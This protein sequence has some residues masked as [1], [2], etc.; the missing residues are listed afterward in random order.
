MLQGWTLAL[1]GGDNFAQLVQWT[2]LVG[3]ALLVFLG[4]RLLGSGR[5][6]SLF[7]AALFV[8]LPQPIIQAATAQNDLIVSFFVAAT[9]VFG[10]RGLQ[11]RA[12]GDL[13]I[14]GL[15]AGLAVGTKGTALVA[16]VPLAILLVAAAAA[17]RPPR[18][19]LAVGLASAVLGALALGSLS[20]IGNTLSSGSP[21][22]GLPEQATK[23]VDPI[24]ANVI[25]SAWT[26]VDLP[27]YELPWLGEALQRP[28]RKLAGDLEIP[29]TDCFEPRFEFR[30]DTT[31]HADRVAFGPIGLLILVPL[32]LFFAVGRRVPPRHRVLAIA[33]ASYF[34]V[35][36]VLLA[37]NPWQGRLF[38]P[39]VALAAPLLALPAVA[40]RFGH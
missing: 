36:V 11:R 19:V 22:G 10:I 35:F 9:A 20:Y 29:C 21:V 18:R 24:P 39:A 8:V 1:T 40:R 17:Y 6:G 15:S 13:V 28:A 23:R 14:G 37:W 27:G 2:A 16:G 33:V 32:V 3:L 30:P 34:V 38:L 25:R 7:A 26:F 31:V 5:R 4:G 12:P